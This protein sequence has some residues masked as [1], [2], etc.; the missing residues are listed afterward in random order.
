[1]RKI[2]ALWLLSLVIVAALA[3][4]AVKAQVDRTPPRIMSGSDLGFRVD[5]IDRRTGRPTGVLVIR[6]DG[7]WV[8]IGPESSSLPVSTKSH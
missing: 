7:Q 4:A 1:M 2:I 3:A 5:G 6:V 8:E